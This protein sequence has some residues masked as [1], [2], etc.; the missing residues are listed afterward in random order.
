LAE[1]FA[2]RLHEM[3]RKDWGYGRDEEL[4]NADLI[5][6]RYRGI[7]PAIGYPSLPDHTEKRTLFELMNVERDAGITLTETSMMVP[8]ASVCGFYFAHPESRYFTVGLIDRDQAEDYAC[9]KGAEVKDV[10]RWL[11]SNLAYDPKE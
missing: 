10:E 2:E 4:S 7:R 6:E 1:A 11:A 8:A 9:R 5:A 3:V